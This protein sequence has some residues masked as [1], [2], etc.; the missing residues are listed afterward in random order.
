MR[1]MRTARLAIS[2]MFDEKGRLHRVSLALAALLLVSPWLLDFSDLAIA[3]NTAWVS[4][5]VIGV[6]S[7]AAIIRFAE[8]KEWIN[9][10]MGVFLV[11]APYGLNF[12]YINSAAAAFVGIGSFIIAISV[13]DL[14]ISHYRRRDS[15]RTV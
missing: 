10:A 6:F 15:G 1:K 14:W 8:W 5:V 11:I 2:R 9:L 12:A 7:L 13:S 4:A 3:A